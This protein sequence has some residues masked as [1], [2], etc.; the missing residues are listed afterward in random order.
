MWMSHCC[1][2]VAKWPHGLK[3]TRLLYPRDFLGKNIGVGCHFLFLGIFLT[4]RS[5]L[6]LL[7][8]QE[9]SLLLSHLGAYQMSHWYL[10]FNAFKMHSLLC[11][12]LSLLLCSLPRCTDI[13]SLRQNF[14]HQLSGSLSSFI[15]LTI[16]IQSQSPIDLTWI[17]FKIPAHIFLWWLPLPYSGHHDLLL[18][19]LHSLVNTLLA[20]CF[21][22]IQCLLLIAA[23]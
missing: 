18:T 9:D 1:C 4:Q 2:L 19:P 20:S 5:N 22:I 16:Y 11:P 15:S 21:T 17:A 7:H 8:W 10:K 6:G 23:R 3:T 13:I 12:D 14:N